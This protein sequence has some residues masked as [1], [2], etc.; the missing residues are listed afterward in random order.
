MTVDIYIETQNI[1]LRNLINIWLLHPFNIKT[2]TLY[3]NI[4]MKVHL[5]SLLFVYTVASKY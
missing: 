1:N 5:V 2:T 4:N 3:V